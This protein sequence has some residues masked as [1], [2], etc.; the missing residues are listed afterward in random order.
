M[1]LKAVG[2]TG[3]GQALCRHLGGQCKPD[4]LVWLS[5]IFAF[6]RRNGLDPL[7]QNREQFKIEA[8][9]TALVG[10]GGVGEAV[11][12]HHIA[13]CQRRLDHG[14]QMVPPGRKHQQR[15]GERVHGLVQHQ[16]AQG[17]GQRRATGFAGQ[18]HR[19]ALGSEGIGQPLDM[20]GFAGPVDAF[21]ADEQARS[22]GVVQSHHLPRWY[23]LTA[24]L[25]SS[26]DGLKWLLPSPLATKYSARVCAGCTAASKA[27]LPGMAM[28]VGGRPA[29]V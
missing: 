17:F 1:G 29:R 16:A 13:P 3:A 15:L 24:R 8:A 9:P 20:G 10:E 2:H 5:N 11:A 26:S 19:P 28:G 23:W 18:C 7:L 25:C 4:R 22:G 14:Q 21:K 6:Q 12:Q 27:A